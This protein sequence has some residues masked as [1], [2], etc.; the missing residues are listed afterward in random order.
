MNYCDKIIGLIILRSID[1]SEYSDDILKVAVGKIMFFTNE[2]L[3]LSNVHGCTFTCLR[4]EG[5][6]STEFNTQLS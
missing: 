5:I 6:S 1:S 4:Y 3:Y 2:T